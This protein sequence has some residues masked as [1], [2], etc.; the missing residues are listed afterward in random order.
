MIL[1][2]FTFSMHFSCGGG[3][4]ISGITVSIRTNLWKHSSC[5]F[6]V[7]Q[8]LSHNGMYFVKNA[9][10]WRRENVFTK[11]DDRKEFV[12]PFFFGLHPLYSG[13]PCPC[14]GTNSAVLA[15]LV[16]SFFPYVCRKIERVHVFSGWYFVEA[17][18]ITKLCV[19]N[20][21]AILFFFF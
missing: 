4:Q 7:Y 17:P 19:L 15:G 8:R 20:N 13:A 16:W 18:M 11:G 12:L 14:M 1:L 5:A 2:S 3:G 6:F 10:N 9:K 21:P